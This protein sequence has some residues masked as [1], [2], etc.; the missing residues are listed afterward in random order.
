MNRPNY[1]TFVVTI[2]DYDPINLIERTAAGAAICAA[3]L[4]IPRA[5][6][7]GWPD[8]SQHH[9]AYALATGGAITEI[10]V[11]FDPDGHPRTYTPGEAP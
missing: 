4:V 7:R 5:D 3:V 9:V 2:D 1:R 11:W 10:A 6:R 8:T